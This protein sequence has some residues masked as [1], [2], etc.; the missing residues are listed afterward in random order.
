MT[1][2]RDSVREEMDETALRSSFSEFATNQGWDASHLVAAQSIYNTIREHGPEAVM[3]PTPTAAE[4]AATITKA[5]ELLA[6]DSAAYFRDEELQEL[7]VEALERQQAA[8]HAASVATTT[9][10][11]AGSRSAT[12]PDTRR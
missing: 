8:P 10:S 3:A 11:S 6:K 12:W 1:W 2:Y 7:M 9:P 5:N 4:D